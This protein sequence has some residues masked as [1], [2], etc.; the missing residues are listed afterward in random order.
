[1]K[2]ELIQQIAQ[3]GAG[4]R[5]A[6][7]WAWNG[8]LEPAEIRRQVRIMKQMGM[9]GFFMHS[10]VGLATPYLEKEWFD[11]VKA[12]IDEAGKLGMEAHL[13][14]EDRW[15]S[16]AAGGLVTGDGRFKACSLRCEFVTDPGRTAASG[17]TLGYFALERRNG[18]L[19]SYRKLAAAPEKPGDYLRVFVLT[20]PPS[21]WFND[22]TYL[23]TM[24]PE[25]VE[26]FITAT[27]ETYAREV[28]GQFGKSVPAIFTDEPNYLHTLGHQIKPWTRKLPERYQ[29]Q[30]GENLLDRLPELFFTFGEDFSAPR[31]RYYRL[32]TELFVTSFARAIG[33]WCERH[34]LALTGHVLR[35]DTLSQQVHSVGAAMPFYEFMQMPGI[36]LLTEHWMIFN[37]VKQMVSVARQ[38]GKKRTLTETYGCTGWDFPFAGHKALGDWQ[39]LL[40][41][42]F[43]CQHLYWY[44]MSGEAKRDYPASIGEQSPWFRQY[45]LVEDYLSRLGTVLANAAARC[46][47]LVLHPIESL[48]GMAADFGEGDS[49]VPEFDRVF[50]RNTTELLKAHV[51]FDFGDESLLARY[52]S[53][54]DGNLRV[55]QSAYSAVLLPE[56]RTLRRSTVNLLRQFRSAGGK[57]FYLGAIP[58]RCEGEPASDMLCE[59]YRGFTR[60][61]AETFASR[62]GESLREFSLGDASG[63]IPALLAAAGTGDDFLT[64]FAVNLGCVPGDRPFQ[65]PAVADRTL[66]FAGVEMRFRHP[67]AGTLYEL[68]P[69]T[70]RYMLTPY[71]YRNGCYCWRTDFAPLESHLYLITR[72]KI[73]QATR[74]DNRVTTAQSR[75]NLTGFTASEDN[76][77]ILDHAE[78]RIADEPPLASSYIL[79]IDSELRRKLGVPVRGDAMVQPWKRPPCPQRQTLP[80]TLRYEFDCRVRPE[81]GIELV[82]ENPEFYR[83]ELNG[84]ATGKTIRG[85]WCDPALK[86]LPLNPADFHIGRNT[87][88]LHCDYHAGMPG[89]ES[90]FLL[91]RFGVR[92]HALTS[93]PKQLQFGD[94]CIQGLPHY[95]G[96]LT[97]GGECEVPESCAGTRARIS[98]PDWHGACLGVAVNGGSETFLGWPPY[99]CTL[100]ELLHPGR[101]RIAVTVYGNRRNALGPFY[102]RGEAPAWVG[103]HEFNRH[104]QTGRRLIPM[105][106]LAE[107]VI[108]LV[109]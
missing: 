90:L 82:L 30:Y 89:L 81:A 34:H 86:C 97:Y 32:A 91:G 51:E 42:N 10:R 53:V 22:A 74:P 7:F 102:F 59:L 19:S 65:A 38:L 27:H 16:G 35:E 11:C 47:L 83:I 92:D 3:P 103:A 60:L 21:S 76:L 70:G 105:G 15:P 54:A 73:M 50:A 66:S 108:E 14:D 93:W 84:A 77:F 45:P 80:L 71:A 17:E 85:W 78:A 107:P 72:Q 68:D 52:G 104:E 25:A 39:Y 75:F 87:L 33:D 9:G 24:N 1:M 40:G 26:Q 37:T 43:H 29:A 79:Q 101:N 58:D 67:E 94:W 98:F 36:D 49:F 56:L 20:D 2:Q 6:P 96:N 99:V 64:L 106:L 18:Q 12:A 4:F 23:D 31:Y 41:I 46:E 62:L 8:R 5:G 48:W 13:Y 88:L 44:S 109:R 63:E 57:I 95:A 69:A 61:E 100:P 28:G 55:G